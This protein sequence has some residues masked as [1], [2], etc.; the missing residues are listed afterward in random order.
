MRMDIFMLVVWLLLL[1]AMQLAQIA[2]QKIELNTSF[3]CSI[4]RALKKE[5]L[6][7]MMGNPVHRGHSVPGPV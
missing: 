4:Q 3:P 2:R 6:V 5:K 1:L 7:V